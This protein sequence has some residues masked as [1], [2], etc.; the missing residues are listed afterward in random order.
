MTENTRDLICKWLNLNDNHLNEIHLSDINFTEAAKKNIVEA[1]THLVC[2]PDSAVPDAN[3]RGFWDEQTGELIICVR[4]CDQVN[5][6][7]IP[8][9]D[10]LIRQNVR[11]Q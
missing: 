8:P 2:P 10:W 9:E 4:I 7:I 3:S 11:I 1:I 6:I 5:A